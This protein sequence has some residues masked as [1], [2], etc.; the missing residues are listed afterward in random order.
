MFDLEFLIEN[1]VGISCIGAGV[2]VLVVWFFMLRDRSF[3]TK[4]KLNAIAGDAW[5]VPDG[6]FEVTLGLFRPNGEVIYKRKVIAPMPK[7]PSKKDRGP[8]T[9]EELIDL[10]GDSVPIDVMHLLFDKDSP[11]HQMSNWAV[12]RK[13]EEI[14]KV[15]K[16][17]LKQEPSEFDVVIDYT[18][19]KGVRNMRTIRPLT[20]YYKDSAFHKDGA[21]WFVWAHDVERGVDREFAMKDIHTWFPLKV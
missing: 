3:P 16:R 1:R 9:K 17:E 14:S 12:Y 10:F 7:D 6:E 15:L 13:L 8:I 18:N 19:Y 11:V 5:K 2:S 21:Q 4:N 20:M